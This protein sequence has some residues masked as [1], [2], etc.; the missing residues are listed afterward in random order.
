M[1]AR[2]GVLK[3]S[4]G[5]FGVPAGPTETAFSFRQAFSF[6]PFA[7]KEKASNKHRLRDL[8]GTTG[9]ET[10]PLPITAIVASTADGTIT[11]RIGREGKPLPYGDRI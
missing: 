3:I 1:W 6:G 4:E 7:S 5:C 8:I 2:I 10:P 9:G 11:K